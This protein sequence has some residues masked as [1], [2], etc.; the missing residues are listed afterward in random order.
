MER[1]PRAVPKALAKLPTGSVAYDHAYKDAMERIKGQASD[2]EELA[3]QVLSWITCA[4][5]LLTT[6]ELQHALAVEVGDSELDKE[7]FPQVED[8]VSVCAGLVTVDDESGIIRLVHYTTQEFFQRTQK[9]WFPNAEVDITTICVTYLSFTVFE[10]AFCQTDEEFEQRL[11]SNPLYV[12][13]A[14]NWGHHA[15]A[16]ST[17]GRGVVEFLEKQA[18]VEASSQALL[19]IKEWSGHSKYSQQFPKQMTGLHLTAYFGVENAARLLIDS[20]SSDLKDGYDRTPLSWAAGNG[21]EIVIRL[22][23]ENGADIDSQDNDGQTPLSWAARN[24]HEAAVR[25]LLGKANPDLEDDNGRTPLSWAARNGHEAVVKLLLG[26]RSI[27]PDLEDNMGQTPLSLAALRGHGEVVNLLLATGAV[28]PD[29]KDNKG[30]TPLSWAARN[31]YKSVVQLLLTK[32]DVD[33]N[34][35]DMYGLTPLSFAA[36]KGH[37][38]VVKMLLAVNGIDPDCKEYGFTPLSLAANGGHEA[39]VKLLLEIHTVCSDFKDHYSGQTPL[40]LAAENGH[41]AVVQILLE[42]G[43]DPNPKDNLSRTPL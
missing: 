25:L 29:S 12:Y 34:S 8:M 9:R 37:E 33:I 43:V 36:E 17:S 35:R 10:T 5:R 24:V 42:K 21:H 2:Q 32:D 27:D 23:L 26:A 20:N 39:V 28:H 6:S 7:N 22:L 31:G 38:V 14:Q 41:E 30:R 15:R 3:K 40:S 11:W 13:A 16:S 18:Q 19:A 4:K 1:S